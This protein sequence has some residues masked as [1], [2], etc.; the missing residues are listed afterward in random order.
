MATGVQPLCSPTW[1]PQ[2]PPHQTRAIDILIGT[3]FKDDAYLTN[4]FSVMPT[5]HDIISTVAETIDQNSGLKLSSLSSLNSTITQTRLREDKDRVAQST[6]ITTEYGKDADNL[7]LF[8]VKAAH[9]KLAEVVKDKRILRNHQRVGPL[10]ERSS[11]ALTPLKR[12]SFGRPQQ[13]Q[14]LELRIVKRL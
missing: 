14:A 1:N 6:F 4:L 3:S 2:T 9:I 7:I 8:E 5:T 12:L 11:T 10:Q 13:C